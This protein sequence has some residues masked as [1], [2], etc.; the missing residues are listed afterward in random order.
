MPIVVTDIGKTLLNS[1]IASEE[2]F[3]IT[4]VKFGNPEVGGDDPSFPSTSLISQSNVVYETSVTRVGVLSNQNSIIWSVFLDASIGDFTI[5]QIGYYAPDGTLCAVANITPVEKKQ[6]DSGQQGNNY[7]H[8]FA[9]KHANIIEAADITLPAETWQIQFEEQIDPL[10]SKIIIGSQNEVDVLK[11]THTIATFVSNISSIED[12]SKILIL[13]GEHYLTSTVNINANFLKIS[14]ESKNAILNTNGYYFNLNGA[15]NELDL[16]CSNFDQINYSSTSH[17][18]INGTIISPDLSTNNL[19]IGVRDPQHA[20]HVSADSPTFFMQA[21]NINSDYA[22]LQF[23]TKNALGVNNYFEVKQ[24]GDEGLSLGTYGSGGQLPIS[25]YTASTKRMTITEDGGVG[26][27]ISTTDYAAEF[28]RS[29]EDTVVQIHNDSSSG[30]GYLSFDSTLG[31]GAIIQ[32]KTNGSIAGRACFF[33]EDDD[34]LF[35]ISRSSILSN[36]DNV[37]LMLERDGNL[38]LGVYNPSYKL[39]VNGTSFFEDTFSVQNSLTINPSTDIAYIHDGIYFGIGNSNPQFP[40]SLLDSGENYTLSSSYRN[41]YIAAGTVAQ[42]ANAS[43]GKSSLVTFSMRN[44]NNSN[45][46]TFFGAIPG[47]V[48]NA[49]AHFVIGQRSNAFAFREDLR[50]QANTGNLGVGTNSP[51]FPLHVKRSG[52]TNV[53]IDASVN[54]DSGLY[55]LSN[56]TQK[57]W[58]RWIDANNNLLIGTI[59]SGADIIFRTGNN[60]LNPDIMTLNDDQ[61]VTISDYFYFSKSYKRLSIGAEA[62]FYNTSSNIAINS[63][64]GE[65]GVAINSDSGSPTLSF[66]RNRVEKYVEFCNLSDQFCLQNKVTNSFI[67]KLSSDASTFYSSKFK[68]G[69]GYKF[70]FDADALKLSIGGNTDLYNRDAQ[71]YISDGINN[72][73]SLALEAA[74][75]KGP[76]ISLG[77]DKTEKMNFGLTG[78]NEFYFQTI[79][80]NGSPSVVFKIEYRPS[81]ETPYFNF[82]QPLKLPSWDTLTVYNKLSYEGML[83]YD[84]DKETI[85][86]QTASGLKDIDPYE[87]LDVRTKP[88]IPELLYRYQPNDNYELNI[89]GKGW[90]WA[91]GYK[92]TSTT[93]SISLT[94]GTDYDII[95]TDDQYQELYNVTYSL[96][97]TSVEVGVTSTDGSGKPAWISIPDFRGQFLRMWDG[98]RGLDSE[99][100]RKVLSTQNDAMQGHAHYLGSQDSSSGHSGSSNMEFIRSYNQGNSPKAYSSPPHVFGEYGDPRVDKETRPT[101][102]TLVGL[103]KII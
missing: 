98:E 55:F 103:I 9:F 65:R 8:S 33:S 47:G 36:V 90:V 48:G 7:Q 68:L 20:I 38:G 17:G 40:F 11:A 30:N 49:G 87:L 14:S 81:D 83:A 53:A 10:L 13:D 94:A 97:G 34:R 54:N 58:I 23:P 41:P 27:G 22:R 62:D 63:G 2:V 21:K 25:F 32:W 37:H 102:I 85:I 50:V 19:G 89:E 93:Y 35:C 56:G 79:L 16:N 82:Y 42:I 75:G 96:L 72:R 73:V 84:K 92:V 3:Q 1:K 59:N 91:A 28:Y 52:S 57:S 4:T 60:A 99:S 69:S 6:N 46:Q 45:S 86:Y 77:L 95:I 51:N 39:H 66:G 64:S 24:H 61:S 12:Y 70:I 88:I 101:N 44:S 18:H 31:K 26:F 74:G 5:T 100:N 29:N 43:T 76:E 67:Y 80:S 78:G 15:S 71:V